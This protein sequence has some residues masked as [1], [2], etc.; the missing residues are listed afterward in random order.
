MVDEELL[1]PS[2]E[3]LAAL[4]NKIK[5]MEAET[6]NKVRRFAR[7]DDELAKKMWRDFHRAVEPMRRE[8]DAVGKVIANYC[9]LQSDLPPMIVPGQGGKE[10]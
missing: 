10:P 7:D 6:H 3:H 8:M 9:A 1:R 5:E 2:R 4:G